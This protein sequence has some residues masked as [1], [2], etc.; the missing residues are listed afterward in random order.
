LKAG[1]FLVLIE[2]S[3]SI[4]FEFRYQQRPARAEQRAQPINGATHYFAQK[5]SKLDLT[6]SSILAQNDGKT[7]CKLKLHGIKSF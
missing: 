4:G 2:F 6:Q 3:V 5:N 7:E 1:H